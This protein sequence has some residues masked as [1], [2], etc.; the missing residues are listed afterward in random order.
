MEGFPEGI[1]ELSCMSFDD[2]WE[3]KPQHIEFVLANWTDATGLFRRFL[4]F[5]QDRAKC[6]VSLEQHKERCRALVKTMERSTIP[7]YLLKY[8]DGP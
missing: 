3:M 2:V 8:N 1:G 5:V 4:D 7:S 6:G